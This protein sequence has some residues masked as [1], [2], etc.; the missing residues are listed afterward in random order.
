MSDLEKKFEEKKEEIEASVAGEV[1]KVKRSLAK[2]MLL[3]IGWTVAALLVLVLVLFGLFA[4]YSKTEDFNRRVA[5]EV[6]KVLEDATGGRV[7]LSKISF[8][9]WHLAVEADGLVIHGLEGPGEA[10]Y[11]AADKILLRV[12]IFDFFTHVA[13]SGI[14]SHVRLNYLGVEHPQFHLI[15][16]KDGKTNQPV[17]KHPSTSKK[18]VIDTLLDLKARQVELANGVALLNNRAIPF[19]LAARD[20]NAEVHYIFLEDRYGAT[21]DLQDLRTRMGKDPEGQAH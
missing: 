16:D 11:L 20:L 21:V 18:P 14:S 8:D 4:S 13:G 3:W 1:A 10:P 9:L 5:K 19:E 7:E 17:P 15:V 12:Q 2:R 6:V